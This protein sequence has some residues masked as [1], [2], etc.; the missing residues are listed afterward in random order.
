MDEEI[1]RRDLTGSEVIEPK[2]SDS[3][4]RRRKVSDLGQAD[5][6]ITNKDNEPQLFLHSATNSPVTDD[7]T[8]NWQNLPPTFVSLPTGVDAI[9]KDGRQTSWKGKLGLLGTNVILDSTDATRP[10]A[11]GIAF[12]FSLKRGKDD[13]T[14]ASM[15]TLMSQAETV[16]SIL[17]ELPPVDTLETLSWH[18]RSERL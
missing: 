17:E 16:A 12:P 13:D 4:S 9:S 3:R 14:N 18:E 1:T 5:G 6:H 10:K 11:G 15:V 7:T 8:R 2:T